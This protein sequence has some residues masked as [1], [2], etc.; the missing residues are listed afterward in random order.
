MD[1]LNN[2]VNMAVSDAKVNSDIDIVMTALSNLKSNAG[3]IFEEPV[4]L[5]LMTIRD[6][7]PAEWQRVRA[8]MKE[9][10]VQISE[11]DRLTTEKSSNHND[12]SII[13]PDETLWPSMVNGAQ[14]LDDIVCLINTHIV[15]EPET[16]QAAALWIVFTWLT[17]VVNV[18][19][20]VNITAPEKRCGKSE[21]LAILGL[22]VYRPL[23]AVN[24][25]SAP[26]FRLI[27]QYH[28][29]LLIDEVDTFLSLHDDMRGI[30]N[31][32]FTRSASFV[33]RCFGD[34]H[35]V[36]QFSVWGAKALCGIGGVD[37]LP[38]L[39]DRSIP[40]RLRRKL[41]GEKSVKARHHNQQL[42]AVLR[43]QLARFAHDI[44]DDIQSYQSIDIPELN[45]RANDCWEPLFSIA[46]I[47]GGNWPKIAISAAITL[48]GMEEYNPTIGE[49]L[50]C[51]VK[52]VFE[53]K[54]CD[55]IKTTDLLEA[56]GRDDELPW[57]TWNKGKLM[58][59]YQ[60]GKRLSEYGIRSGTVRLGTKTAKGFKLE[61]F[62]EAFDR[63]LASDAV[64]ETVTSSQP[65]PQQG[66]MSF[67]KGNKENS[68]TNLST[69]KPISA[70]ECDD[71]TESI[72]EMIDGEIF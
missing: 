72:P 44:K 20:L 2:L 11:I 26:M 34:H 48:H 61:Q 4:L 69:L 23:L 30:L 64:V 36:K 59:P 10:K 28:P 18:A 16:V 31:A 47:A 15:A 12:I 65:L 51:S 24:M 55:R 57:A 56:L 17:D 6:S 35:D 3:A 46:N 5:A 19:P 22:L 41:K 71:V 45:D 13:F 37:K 50:L 29:T 43:Q 62:T 63:Y 52:D 27:D 7:N 8:R 14:L 66:F 70:I 53:Q 25:G 38:T 33:Y 21:M 68:V 39:A 67:E 60:L 58:T 42:V 32:G 54:G 49:Q 1:N 9:E 40:I